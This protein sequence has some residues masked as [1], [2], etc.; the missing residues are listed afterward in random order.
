MRVKNIIFGI[1]VHVCENGKYLESI[2]NDAVITY[3]EIIE[4]ARAVSAKA[5]STKI[6]SKK[7]ISTNL[8]EKMVTCKMEN[9]YILL[10]FLL[11][12][13]SLLIIAGVTVSL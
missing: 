1:L 8:N 12:T 9:F 7:T 11:I 3:S 13:I 2:I 5:V 4:V 6:I 10:T